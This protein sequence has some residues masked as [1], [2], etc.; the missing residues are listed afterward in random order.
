VTGAEISKRLVP[1]LG[2]DGRCPI[3]ELAER[4]IANR[5]AVRAAAVIPVRKGLVPDSDGVAGEPVAPVRERLIAKGE[6][7]TRHAVVYVVECLVPDG[8]ASALLS[9]DGDRH[10]QKNEG[11]K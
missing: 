3:V 7:V 10:P 9:E 8:Y 2:G 11:A 1:D 6:R 4:L 5:H